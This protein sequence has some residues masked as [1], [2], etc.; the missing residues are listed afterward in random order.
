MFTAFKVWWFT[1]QLQSADAEARR[2]A[3]RSLAA[4]PDGRAADVVSRLLHDA[5]PELR[6]LAIAS[7]DPASPSRAEVLTQALTDPEATVR[8]AAAAGLLGTVTIPVL[9]TLAAASRGLSRDT[10]AA[11]FLAVYKQD[12]FKLRAPERREIVQTILAQAGDVAAEVMV[13]ALRDGPPGVRT[14]VASDIEVLGPDRAVGPLVAALAEADKYLGLAVATT[15]GNLGD[16]RAVDGLIA[17]LSNRNLDV[18]AAI[19]LGRL[20]DP[21]AVD[22]LIEVLRDEHR[23]AS[24]AA[25][26]ALGEIGDGRAVPALLLVLGEL[27]GKTTRNV[28]GSIC[29]SLTQLKAVGGYEAVVQAFQRRFPAGPA[30][31]RVAGI[32]AG[33]AAEGDTRAEGVLAH[34]YIRGG[35]D[36]RQA[37]EKLIQMSGLL[38]AANAATKETFGLIQAGVRVDIDQL[39]KVMGEKYRRK[40]EQQPLLPWAERILALARSVEAEDMVDAGATSDDAPAPHEEATSEG[41]VAL[42]NEVAA[43]CRSGGSSL[44]FRNVLAGDASTAEAT[45]IVCGFFDHFATRT[46]AIEASIG[47]LPSVGSLESLELES[48]L[49]RLSR[50]AVRAREAADVVVAAALSGGPKAGLFVQP[51]SVLL[52]TVEK[53]LQEILAFLEARTKTKTPP[54]VS[55]PPAVRAPEPVAGA[56]VQHLLNAAV[57]GASQA[58]LDA[59]GQGKVGAADAGTLLGAVTGGV[60]QGMTRAADATPAEPP[61]PPPA[62]SSDPAPPPATVMSWATYE[63]AAYGFRFRYPEGWQKVP[64]VPSVILHPPD[65]ESF[66]TSSGDKVQ[67]VFSPALTL[68]ML[69]RGK[70]TGQTP[71]QVFAD[72]KRMLP[73]YFAGY[74]CLGERPLSLS[75]GVEAMEIVFDFRKAGRPF[76]AVLAYVVRPNAIYILDGSGLTADFV[77]HESLLRECVGSLKVT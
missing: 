68:L 22:P 10:V 16:Q 45:R 21:R 13:T 52:G 75:G 27:A 50:E 74:A 56:A 20:R 6:R 7:L 46:A 55:P 62:V 69:R 53:K 2:A 33:W 59:L 58:I 40:V 66:Q 42:W 60:V 25:A 12:P 1:R 18:F 65:A 31:D 72:F 39:G 4:I 67:Q 8:E 17:A 19:A 41:V 14:G 48:D 30:L 61:P 54:A 77:K 73:S 23:Q 63:N 76:R 57:T 38:A 49:I 51:L 11:L 29:Q 5:D 47:S 3:A 37:V 15:L 43:K 64:D 24:D 44:L 36:C 35:A 32:L 9:R 26:S 28:I 70:T 34:A 71:M